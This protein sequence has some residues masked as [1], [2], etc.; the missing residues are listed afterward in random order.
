[1]TT[2][3]TLTLSDLCYSALNDYLYLESRVSLLQRK[4]E[5]APKGLWYKGQHMD[6]K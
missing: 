5:N 6:Q 1:M 4:D 2:F 3:L